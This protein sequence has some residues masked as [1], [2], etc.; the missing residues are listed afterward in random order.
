MIQVVGIHKSFGSNEVLKGLSLDVHDGE[1]VT[2][3]GSSGCGKSVTLKCIIGL[4]KP[5]IGKILVDGVD[6]VSL[7]DYELRPIRSRFGM[8]FQS[9]ALFDYMNV[10]D[11]ISLPL[12][13]QKV[14]SSSE[15]KER[16]AK[17][18]DTVGLSGKQRVMPAELSG[19]MK[20][21]VALARAL[22]TRPRYVL[23]DEPTTG[24]DPLIAISITRL[25][26]TLSREF[27]TTSVVVTH[28]I[29][30]AFAISDSVA[31][32][33]DGRI[34]VQASVDE[35][36]SSNMPEVREFIHSGEAVAGVDPR[37]REI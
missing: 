21:R 19:G 27:G 31:V 29:G 15:I 17:M 16:V 14:L 26:H 18:L 3:L 11:N 10:E 22:V 1:I 37:R 32:L 4:L 30:T 8:V 13:E 36:K 9:S 25:I 7:S 23:Y 20:K 35:I 12:F 28:E 24:L 33:I 34:I 5:D 2:I 6:I